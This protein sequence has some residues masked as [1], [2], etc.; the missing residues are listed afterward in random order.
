MRYPI[1]LDAMGGDHAPQTTIE[2]ACR[3]VREGIPVLLVGDEAV[4]RPMLPKGVD[5]PILHASET[6]GMDEAPSRAVR[7]RP[8]SSVR[9]AARAVKEGRASAVISFGNT[10]ALMAA[11]LIE[12]GRLEGV[13]RPAVITTLPRSDGGQLVLLD[14]GANVDC[15]PSHLGQFG[16]MGSVFARDVLHVET[17]RVGL[18]SNGEEEG[19][20][21][22]QVRAAMPVLE[23]MPIRFIG[24]VEPHDALH[25]ACEVVVCDGFV[26]NVM[27]KSI[28]AAIGVAGKVLKEEILGRPG[29]KLGVKLLQGA[30]QRYRARTSATAIGGAFLLGVDGLVLVGHGAA[31]AA[32]VHSAIRRADFALREELTAHIGAA[33]SEAFRPGPSTDT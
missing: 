13:E 15:K 33:I 18:L 28:E 7:N 1:A 30:L 8:E 11:C 5:L 9:L 3:A 6:I 25:G 19:K 26:G 27:L 21:N 23:Q 17:P 22:E 12:L 10:G 20:G 16:V 4:L 2:G 32:A 14:L 24:A 29:A 31:D